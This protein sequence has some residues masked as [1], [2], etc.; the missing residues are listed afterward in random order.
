LR[1]KQLA[2]WVAQ[3]SGWG[4][5]LFISGFSSYLNNE[6]SRP[7]LIGFTAIFL[8][9]ILLSHLYRN[10]IVRIGWLKF[11]P[12]KALIPVAFSAALLSLVMGLL[13]LTYSSFIIG[14][15]GVF[16]S[17]DPSNAFLIWL[18]WW[19]IF[20]V[21]SVIYFAFHF[22]EKSRD[23]EIK[24]LRLEAMRTEVELNNLK[25]QL[26]PHFMFNAMNSIRALVDE[27]PIIAKESITKL[28]N[29]LRNTLLMGRKKFVT[30]EEELQLIEDYLKLES[31]RYEE[32]LKVELVIDSSCS[33]FL[34]PPLMVQTLVENSIKHGISKLPG[35]GLLRLEI[36]R[37]QDMLEIV[38]E[39]TGK[40]ANG[41]SGS[42]GIGIENTKQRLQLLYEGKSHFSLREL[43]DKVVAEIKLPVRNNL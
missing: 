5:Y 42:T 37:N 27:D 15:T 38:V 9:G 24:N 30:V 35:G 4:L 23:E 20:M 6:L 39:N 1:R 3:F 14:R 26:N 36:R 19:V 16:S 11:T 8:S 31:I 18:N 2:Y 12:I 22:F 17:L 33:A 43:Q 32:R 7:V 13:Q 21:W 25:A 28:S 34:I 40:L 41:V 10:F 29:I